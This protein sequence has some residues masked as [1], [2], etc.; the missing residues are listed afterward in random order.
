MK[1]LENLHAIVSTGNTPERTGAVFEVAII[2]ENLLGGDG[3]AVS[4]CLLV[5]QSLRRLISR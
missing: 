3:V 4:I 5:L 2:R 1:V